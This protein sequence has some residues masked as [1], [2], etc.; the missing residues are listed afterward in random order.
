MLAKI[1]AL[2]LLFGILIGC[3]KKEIRFISIDGSSTVY[4]IAQAISEEFSKKYGKVKISIGISGTGGGFKKFTRGEIDIANASRPIRP[5]EMDL[6][7]RNKIEYIELPIAFDGLAIVV[8]P[9]NKWVDYLTTKELRK[10]WKPDAEGKV[11]KW[12]QIREGWPNEEI[13][14]YGPGVADGTFDYF[15]EAIVGE[16]KSSRGDYTSSEDDNVLVHGVAS[17]KLALGYFGLSYYE[18]NRDKLRLVP[19]DDEDDTNG[20]GPILPKMESIEKGTYQPLSR[21]LFIYVN[22]KS[23]ERKEIQDFVEFFLKNAYRL[24]REAKYVPLPREGYRLVEAR[25]RNR[26]TGSVFFNAKPG[27]N[28]EGVLKKEK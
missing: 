21:P 20:K 1:C 16:A 22:R 5:N 27:I 7:K 26:I 3:A 28:I 10:L 25:F 11:T 18:E 17:D 2:I 12:N 4:P 6:A 8:N 15:T 24:V 19:I 13:H 14:L 9:K 23:A